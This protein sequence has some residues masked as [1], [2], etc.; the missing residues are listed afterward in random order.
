MTRQLR[1][2]APDADLRLRTSA[3]T[4]RFV[5]SEVVALDVA[6]GEYFT[7]NASGTTLWQ[8]LV[9]GA[10]M[11]DLVEALTA[12]FHIERDRAVADVDAFVAA[13]MERD[14]LEQEA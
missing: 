10:T 11:T 2:A 5:E 6:R 13:L 1:D 4:W 14:L 7:L 8:A 3:V 12:E 9:D